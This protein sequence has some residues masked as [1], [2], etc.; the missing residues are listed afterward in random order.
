MPVLRG[1]RLVG[2]FDPALDRRENVLT[3]NALHMQEDE[4]PG[5]RDAVDNA[6]DELARWLGVDA[7]TRPRS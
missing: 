1:D 3:I 5:D 4:R 6:I 7:V 2:R